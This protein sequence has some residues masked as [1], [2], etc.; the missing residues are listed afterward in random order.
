[1][2]HSVACPRSPTAVR[3]RL[4]PVLGLG[5]RYAPDTHPSSVLDYPARY[6]PT[7]SLFPVACVVSVLVLDRYPEPSPLCLAVTIIDIRFYQNSRDLRIDEDFLTATYRVGR[8][9]EKLAALKARKAEKSGSVETTE[10]AGQSS[11]KCS[12]RGRTGQDKDLG[13]PEV[14]HKQTKSVSGSKA[15]KPGV[16]SQKGKGTQWKNLYS[17]LQGILQADIDAQKKDNPNG[18]WRYGNRNH[19]SVV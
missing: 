2:P 15:G 19:R 1:M 12:G 5:L 7:D 11:G 13:K 14:D 4:S 17:A 9:V 8:H 18:C 3:D 16:G 6:S 10:K